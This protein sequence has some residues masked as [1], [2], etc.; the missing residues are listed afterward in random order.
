MVKMSKANLQPSA[1]LSSSTS[2][3]RASRAGMQASANKS[4]KVLSVLCSSLPEEV[5]SQKGHMAR[6]SKA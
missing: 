6:L 5:S 3:R 1:I 2:E 4:S